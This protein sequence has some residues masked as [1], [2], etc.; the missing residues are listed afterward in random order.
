MKQYSDDKSEWFSWEWKTIEEEIGSDYAQHR[1]GLIMSVAA[2]LNQAKGEHAAFSH[3]RDPNVF[4]PT[5]IQFNG[6]SASFE[7]LDMC[8]LG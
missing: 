4:T 6:V 5:C 2:L 3:W 8:T 7:Y 1:A